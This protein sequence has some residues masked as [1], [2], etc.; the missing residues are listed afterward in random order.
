[1]S[2][3]PVMSLS[4]RKCPLTRRN[5]G[6]LVGEVDRILEHFGD[7][8]GNWRA[9]RAGQGD[10]GEEWVPLERFNDGGQHRGSR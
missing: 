2:D 3:I 9:L 8:R 7:Q 6:R 4:V 1:M 5:Q 10:V